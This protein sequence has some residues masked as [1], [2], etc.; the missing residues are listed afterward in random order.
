MA[1]TSALLSEVGIAN[2]ASGL[3]AEYPIESLDDDRPIGRFMA[4]EF[5]YVRDE[6]LQVYPWHFAKKRALLPQASPAPAFGWAYAYTLP[7]DCLRALPIRLG[8]QHNYD[9]VPHEVESGQVLTD[10]EYNGVLPVHYI[11]RVT[12]ASKFPPLFARTM[13]N[14][15]AVIASQRITGKATYYQ[16]ARDAYL[17]SMQE[18][19]MADSLSRGTPESVYV[20]DGLQTSLSVRGV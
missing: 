5:G 1:N 17:A 3:L 16:T 4:R 2:M 10:Y 14:R 8:G 15:L 7:A 11:W 13:A 19:V 20:R 6:M 12:D 18:A 9:P